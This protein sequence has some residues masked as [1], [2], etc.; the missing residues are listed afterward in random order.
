[1]TC[2]TSPGTQT[3]HET[4][5]PHRPLLSTLKSRSLII[6]HGG[7]CADGAAAA[8]IAAAALPHCEVRAFLY[9]DPEYLNLPA[10]PGILALD[11]TPPADR[12][13]EFAAV[14]TVVLDHHRRDL[15]KPYGK[16]GIFGENASGESGA[17]LAYDYVYRP[18]LGYH[19][20][21]HRIATMSAAYDTWAVASPDWKPACHLAALLQ[22][23]P[24]AWCLSVPAR[25]ALQQAADLGVAL[26]AAK[27]ADAAKIAAGAV[28][29]RIGGRDVAIV[30]TTQVNLI[31]IPKVD[32]VAGFR[33]QCGAPRMKWSLRSRTVNV[34]DIARRNGGNGHD[35]SAGFLVPDDGRS[36]YAVAEALFAEA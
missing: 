8:M 15:V 30:P 35:S 36:P 4:N 28:C 29:R 13:V 34:G 23:V 24:L 31:D 14:G 33:Y 32:I 11:I 18:L 22:T 12:A 2:D 9:D 21:W 10:T 20:D 16:L 3:V 7:N 17:W 5:E 27:E 1:M 19:G 6:T 26:H 25:V